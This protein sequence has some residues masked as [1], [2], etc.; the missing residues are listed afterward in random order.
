MWKFG[1]EGPTFRWS[2]KV[3]DLW[4]AVGDLWGRGGGELEALARSVRRG[5]REDSA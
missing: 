3:S 4:R 1:C 5:K 2:L